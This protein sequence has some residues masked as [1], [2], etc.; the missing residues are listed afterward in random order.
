MTWLAILEF[1]RTF[2]LSLLPVLR[3]FDRDWIR[4]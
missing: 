3:P 4:I 1:P 2:G